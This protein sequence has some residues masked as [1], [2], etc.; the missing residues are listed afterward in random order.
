MKTRMLIGILMTLACAVGAQDQQTSKDHNFRIRGYDVDARAMIET[1]P[2]VNLSTGQS[3]FITTIRHVGERV[4]TDLVGIK[5]R[6]T[7]SEPGESGILTIASAYEQ[8]RLPQTTPP[9]V[10]G[11]YDWDFA[12][13]GEDLVGIRRRDRSG[14]KKKVEVHIYTAASRYKQARATLATAFDMGP[15]GPKNR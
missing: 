12:M 5:A 7:A 9:S 2:R 10:A 4:I 1:H 15:M 3:Q 8:R 6:N 14:R 13:A 11:D